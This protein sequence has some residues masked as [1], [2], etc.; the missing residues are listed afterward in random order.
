[1]S[2]KSTVVKDAVSKKQM[3]RVC[4]MYYTDA[5]AFKALGIAPSTFRRLCKQYGLLTPSAR[6]KIAK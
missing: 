1:M 4:R 6:K 2:I 5:D 3:E